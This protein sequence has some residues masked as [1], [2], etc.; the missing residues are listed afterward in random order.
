VSRSHPATPWAAAP[1][2]GT[3]QAL[4]PRLVLFDGVCGFCD[5]AVRLLLR[6]DRRG[7]LHFAP[8]QGETAEALRR[9]H[10]EIPEELETLVYVESG[11]GGERVFLRSE[12]LFRLCRA[13][14]GRFRPVAWLGVLPRA[15]TD[16][17]Y[18]AFVRVRY[19]FGRLPDCRLPGPEE[20]ERF[21]P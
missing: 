4:P 5:R 10:P 9:R 21:L 15:L 17:A 13:L 7:R 6:A 19:L 1:A 12:A 18:A 14:G 20:R 16:L 11:P 2:A 3:P 8:L